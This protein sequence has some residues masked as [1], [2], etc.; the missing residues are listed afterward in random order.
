MDP[1]D[2]VNKDTAIRTDD[3]YTAFESALVYLGTITL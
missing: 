3:Q 2:L 1:F